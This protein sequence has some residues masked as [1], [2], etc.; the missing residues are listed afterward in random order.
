VFHAEQVSSAEILLMQRVSELL[1]GVETF[2]RQVASI[3]PGDRVIA[4]VSGGIDS[5][6]LLDVLCELRQGLG[7]DVVVAH[8]DHGLRPD[9][10]SDAE[11]VAAVARTLGLS[12][13]T[14]TMD[15][16]EHAN[17]AGLSVETA[18]R[19]LRYQFLEEVRMATESRY[20]ATGHHASDQAETVLMRML[21]GSGTRGLAAMEALR[22]GQILRPLLSFSRKTIEEYVA[23]KELDY[24]EDLTN[25]DT[26]FLR[27]RIRHQLLP[28]LESDYNPQ[29]TRTLGHTATVLRDD[30]AVLAAQAQTALET[31]VCA[32]TN[33]KVIL[34]AS[35]LLRYHIAIQRRILRLLLS[36]MPSV[37][38]AGGF[39]VVERLVD[40]VGKSDKGIIRLCGDLWAQRTAQW[41]IIRDGTPNPFKMSMELPGITRICARGVSLEARFLPASLMNE[42]RPQLGTW[43]AALDADEIEYQTLTLRSIR[44]GDRLQPLG[45]TGSKKISDL[46]VDEKWPRLLRDEVILLTSGEQIAWVAGLRVAQSFRVKPR[47]K[48]ILYLHLVGQYPLPEQA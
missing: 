4:A 7:Y 1:P 35:P 39:D 22:D 32:Q 10:A 46:L 11:F 29:L 8:L 9:S 41:L 25:T 21:R 47:S 42:L 16:G 40:L 43:R 30:E 34:A 45:M 27:N 31:V 28:H 44:K 26:R 2:L 6:A 5:I 15:V 20:I 19:E 18:G 14:R 24:R 48:Q 23:E 38:A 17:N 13:H 3:N 33:G 12:F 36:Q 37:E